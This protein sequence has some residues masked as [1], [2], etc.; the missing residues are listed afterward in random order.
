MPAHFAQSRIL[1]I[2]SLS[3][4]APSREQIGV[5]GGVLADRDLAS[6]DKATNETSNA[7]SSLSTAASMQS[8]VQ[9]VQSRGSSHIRATKIVHTIAYTLQC[10][11]VLACDSC[12]LRNHARLTIKLGRLIVLSESSLLGWFLQVSL[13]VIIKGRSPMEVSLIVIIKQVSS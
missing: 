12:A 6:A 10:E 8:T 1:Q 4:A 13:I 11:R 7:E 3:S 5:V 2:L 9:S